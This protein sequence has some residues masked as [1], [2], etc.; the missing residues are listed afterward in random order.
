MKKVGNQTVDCSHWLNY[1]I[2]IIIIIYF[3]YLLCS[4]E[5]R[6]SYRFIC[7]RWQN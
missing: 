7:K 1:F 3:F 2:I 5:E 4:T 6:N